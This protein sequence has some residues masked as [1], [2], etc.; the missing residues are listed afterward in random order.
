MKD[1]E[2]LTLALGF[3]KFYKLEKMSLRILL[4]A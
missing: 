3:F 2:V 4:N 1:N